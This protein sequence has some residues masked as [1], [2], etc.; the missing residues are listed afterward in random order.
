[1]RLCMPRGSAEARAVRKGGGIGAPRRACMQSGSGRAVVD[2]GVYVRMNE[3]V[4]VRTRTDSASHASK[5][6]TF[7]SRSGARPR[8]R[9]TVA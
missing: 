7:A 1:V 6:H 9:W 4:D 2:D 8:R 3:M 5:L